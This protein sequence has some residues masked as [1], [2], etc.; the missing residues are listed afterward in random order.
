MA[1]SQNPTRA[2][3]FIAMD[4]SDGSILAMGSAPSFNANIFARPFTQKTYEALTSKANDAP[5]L[6]RVT[7]SGYPTGS[8]FKPVTALATLQGNIVTP[9]K[10]ID[11]TGHW[12]YGNRPTHYQNA[13]GASFGTINIQKAITVS[14][15]IFFFQL[16]AW[17]SKTDVIQRMAKQLGFGRKTGID[18]PGELPGVVPSRSGARTASRNTRRAAPTTSRSWRSTPTRR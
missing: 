16:G 10:T 6:N 11:D 3:A 2:G 17:A 9:Q 5:L 18:L 8:T 15:D 1:N 12:E 14:S 13:K 7:A 4:P